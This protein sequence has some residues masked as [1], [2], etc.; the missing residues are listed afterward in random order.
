MRQPDIPKKPNHTGWL[1]WL[2][3][4]IAG[5]GG[6]ACYLM[7]QNSMNPDMRQQMMLVATI[8]TIGIGVCVIAATAHWWMHR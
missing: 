8:A 3:F 6:L 2:A 4:L 5:A 1:W 7:S